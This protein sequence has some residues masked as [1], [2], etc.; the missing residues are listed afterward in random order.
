M[1]V[2]VLVAPLPAED[3]RGT[4]ERALSL[5]QR[6]KLEEAVEAYG[7]VV[8]LNAGHAGAWSNLGVA[9]A[10]L[11]RYEEAIGAY[12]RALEIVPGDHRIR[13]NLALAHY[14]ANAISEAAEELASL[15]LAE[16]NDVR[17]T[18]LLA[19]CRLRL[20]D[21]ARV[22]ELLG[23]LEAAQPDNR[24]LLY[25]LGMALVRG[26]KEEKGQRL[27][28]RLMAGG[29]TAEAHYLLGSAAFMA[30]NYPQAVEEFSR[31]IALDPSLPSLNSYYGRA[32][33]FTGDAEGAESVLRDAVA[34]DPNDFEAQYHLASI[35]A[36]LGR[37]E[38]ARLFA[39]RAVQLRPQAEAA[40][41][42]LVSLD[43]SGDTEPPLD[44]SPLVDRPAPD[45]Q[46]R[47]PDG[48][49]FRLSSLRGHP[50][51]LV[52][53]SYT[54]PQLRHGAPP[55]NALHARYQ[56]RVRFLLVYIREAHPEGEAWQSTVNRREGVSLPE[57]AREEE[58]A[59]HAALCRRRLD[60][61]YE[62][63]LDAMDGRAEAAFDA[64]PS[65][66]FV[67]D[68]AGQVRFESRL[69]VETF[70]PEALEAALDLVAR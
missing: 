70:R 43:H 1:L 36:T 58:R 45:V 42:L 54:C 23:P 12:R 24:A 26:G 47:R 64:F 34:A 22:E 32:L 49:W 27:V 65:R 66:V 52:L 6:G 46:L 67:V 29:D 53:G 50:L 31:A 57:A 19:D 38:E 10:A 41:S 68:A 37:P 69:D 56:D 15:H 2:L 40:R 59:E 28:E 20:G 62:I 14:K 21:F 5:H 44:V 25:L 7:E 51:V 3:L 63:A 48:T 18:L 55:L 11:G 33:L 39:D 16:P 35:L 60:I 61:R 4:Y 9:L 13:R 17:T 8:E 30:R